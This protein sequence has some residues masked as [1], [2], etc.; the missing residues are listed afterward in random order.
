MWRGNHQGAGS[1]DKG[2]FGSHAEGKD[3]ETWVSTSRGYAGALVSA[4]G[5]EWPLASCG[6]AAMLTGLSA[7][8][9]VGK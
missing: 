4:H 9:S 1:S 8:M 6:H 5:E 7:G 3:L 2:V